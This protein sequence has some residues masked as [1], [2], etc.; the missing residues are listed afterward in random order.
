MMGYYIGDVPAQDLVI[1][2]YRADEQ[3]TLDPFTDAEVT[4]YSPTGE[5][6]EVVGF[7]A[8]INYEDNLI[9]IEWPET[10]P[11]ETAGIYELRVAVSNDVSGVSEMVPPVRVTVDGFDGWHTLDTARADWQDA[12]GFDP[13]LFEMLT[14]AKEQVIAYAPKLE[15]GARPPL[16]Y[17]NAQLAQA[18]NLWNAA[19]TDPAS[20]SLGDD[21]FVIRPYPLDWIIKQILRPKNGIPVVG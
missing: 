12:P 10:S 4:L 15:T 19:K 6:V 20:G 16:A 18:R 13:W 17:R 5:E 2:P 21:T 8:F 11:F 14:I 7:A 1:D 3:I 9:V